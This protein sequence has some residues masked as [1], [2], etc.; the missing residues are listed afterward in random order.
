MEQKQCI[1]MILAG[2]RGE[3]LGSLTS[4]IAKPAVTFGGNHRIIDFTLNNCKISG[5]Y[6]IGVLTQYLPSEL[7]SHI[8]NINA[9][10][11]ESMIFLLPSR[12]GSP[13]SGTADAIYRNMTFL[14]QAE[15]EDVLILSGDH[16]YEMDY[17]EM[18][19][20]HR[21]SEADATIASTPVPF[22]ETHRFG[23]LNA[24]K[25]GRITQFEEKPKYAESNLA[26][27]GV[28][29]F[30]WEVLKRILA[31]D[32]LD[33]TSAH[34]FGKNIIPNMLKDDQNLFTY[35]FDG[36]WKDIGTVYSLWEAHMEILYSPRFNPM[37]DT[38][39]IIKQHKSEE[40]EVR[41]SL[42][43]DQRAVNGKISGSVVS[44]NVR[45][46]ESSVITDCV[47]MPNARIGRHVKL[48][49]VIVGEGA[50]ILNGVEIGQDFGSE[51]FIENKICSMGVSLVAPKICVAEGMKFMANSH[52][53]ESPT[54]EMMKRRPTN[55]KIFPAYT[56][57]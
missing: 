25:N 54:T 14:E 27:M 33:Q 36:Y 18:L 23:I 26:S 35:T 4:H 43:T 20:F 46:G 1:A 30:K 7:H 39:G 6:N 55:R 49:N 31:S 24:N 44:E 11:T 19:E 8:T 17:R 29:M 52:I 41:Q 48:N 56:A 15:P 57:H 2:G 53:D 34:D 22:H 28:Y 12:S 13:Y 40:L 16:V 42:I 38:G 10:D 37:N 45:I 32:S 9:A 5:I 51:A 3:R 50:T 21:K 47:I